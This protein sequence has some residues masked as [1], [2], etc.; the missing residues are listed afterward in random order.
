VPRGS[1][2]LGELGVKD[3]RFIIVTSA[4]CE[5]TCPVEKMMSDELKLNVYFLEVDD[6]PSDLNAT[7]DGDQLGQNGPSVERLD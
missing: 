6:C 5:V 2:T 3:I 7:I 1:R 4:G